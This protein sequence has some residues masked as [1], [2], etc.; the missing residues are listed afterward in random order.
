MEMRSG[1]MEWRECE[2]RC[3]NPEEARAWIEGRCGVAL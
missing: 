1:Q 2:E 3:G